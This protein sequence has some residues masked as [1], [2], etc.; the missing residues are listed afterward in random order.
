MST[1]KYMVTG[2]GAKKDTGELYT[3]AARVKEDEKHGTYGYLD[4]KD[5]YYIDG[6]TRPLGSVILL[7]LTEA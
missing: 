4:E 5:R 3:R 1:R 2:Y 7:E 6:E